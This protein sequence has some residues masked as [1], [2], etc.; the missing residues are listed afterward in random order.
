MQ[1]NLKNFYEST[2]PY[3][4]RKNLYRVTKLNYYRLLSSR[5]NRDELLIDFDNYRCIFI[6]VPKTGGMS[7]RK[8]LFTKSDLYPHLTIRDYQSLL[9]EQEVGSYYKFAFV[10]NP[11]DRLVSAYSFLRAG[12][13]NKRGK[14]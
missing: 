14:Q 9:S 2:L 6:H 13:L 7:V 4:W 1:A 10:R 12:G 5:A 8:T 3:R 11:W